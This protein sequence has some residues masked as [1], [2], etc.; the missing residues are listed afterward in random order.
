MRGKTEKETGDNVTPVQTTN[1][2]GPSPTTGGIPG[3]DSMYSGLQRHQNQLKRL[4]KQLNCHP[5]IQMK[6]MMIASYVENPFLHTTQVD[7]LLSGFHAAAVTAGIKRLVLVTQ[8]MMYL[9][10]TSVHRMLL[11]KFRLKYA[12]HKALSHVLILW[13]PVLAN[14]MQLGYKLQYMCDLMRV[15]CRTKIG[16]YKP[17]VCLL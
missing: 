16:T 10:V 12:L 6:R 4:I 5:L 14:S 15:S 1:D 7:P 17:L 9:C 13:S 8:L 11:Y 3:L 2:E